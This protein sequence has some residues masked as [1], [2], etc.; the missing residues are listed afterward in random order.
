MKIVYSICFLLTSFL[1]YSQ[2]DSTE[3]LED[4]SNYGEPE[5]VKRY[6][7]QKVL[8][9]TPQ[10]IISIGYEYMGEFH[11]PGIRISE[12]L[13]TLEDRHVSQ[14][15]VFKA[16]LNI[17]VVATNK[18][19]WQLGANYWG[20]QFQVENPGSNAFAKQLNQSSLISAG[21]NTTVFKPLNETNFLIFQASADVNGLFNQEAKVTSNALTISAT[22]IYGWK[23]SEKNMIGA[24]I[25]RTYRAGRLMYFPVLF[26][27]KTFNDKWGMELLL[28]A[29]GFVRY[30]INTSNM[31]QVG[32]ELE[33]NQFSMPIP[34]T[35]RDLFYIQRGELKPRIMWDKKITGFLW[36]SAQVGLRYNYRFDV[37]NKYD[38]KEDNERYFSSKLGNPLYF[39]FSLNFVSP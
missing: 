32:F 35:Q 33:G 7:T 39:N 27:N 8:N 24:G 25:A 17:P 14:V 4:Y 29:R 12:T 5:G 30:N 38:G 26:W 21:L 34:S 23:K 31:I 11:M 18:I 13:P 6:C 36:F 19:I 2:T 16:Q 9:Q 22:G 15:N 3:V 10:K 37:M 20:S 1:S 28:P